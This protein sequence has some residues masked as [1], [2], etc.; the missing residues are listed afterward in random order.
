MTGQILKPEIVSRPD[1]SGVV[2]EYNILCERTFKEAECSDRLTPA[3]GSKKIILF[4][5]AKIKTIFKIAKYSKKIIIYSIVVRFVLWWVIQN[6][7]FYV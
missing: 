6:I 2:R 4:D 1:P 3:K 5:M 7:Y